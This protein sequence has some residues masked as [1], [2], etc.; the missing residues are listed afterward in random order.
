MSNFLASLANV[1]RSLIWLTVLGLIGLGGWIGYQTFGSRAALQQQLADKQR[2]VDE[3]AAKITALANDNAVKQQQIEK[4][5]LALRLSK[6]DHRVAEL[7]VLQQWTSEPTKKQRTKF[8]FAEVDTS[9][10]ALGT[11]KTFTVDGDTVYI[12]AWVV[13]YADELVEAGDP[14]RG[15]SI[16]LFRRVFGENQE[17]SKGYPLDAEGTRPVAYGHAAAEPSASEKKIWASFWDFANSPER[18]KKAGI[19]AAHGEAPYVRLHEGKRYRVVLR[20]SGGLSIET[21]DEPA[22]AAKAL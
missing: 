5:D 1:L 16:C 21:L 8:Q 22:K 17:P 2:Q 15:T 7:A 11:P 4:L 9:G 18:A 3:Q 20:S 13:K 10:R 12:D 19:R 6:I 14:L